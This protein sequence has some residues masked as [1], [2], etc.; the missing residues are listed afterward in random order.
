[1]RATGIQRWAAV[2][3]SIAEVTIA[4]HLAQLNAVLAQRRGE[5]PDPRWVALPQLAV[6]V[7]ARIFPYEKPRRIRDGK[8]GCQCCGKMKARVHDCIG[9]HFCPRCVAKARE[10]ATKN[11]HQERS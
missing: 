6:I 11:S 4:A 7:A 1:M 8:A 5:R 9:L 2:A 3:D 10:L